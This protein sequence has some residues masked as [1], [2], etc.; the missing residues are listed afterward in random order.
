MT[1][2]A[3]RDT[4]RI[5]QWLEEVAD[6][7]IPVLSVVDLGIVREVRW[8]GDELVVTVTPTYSGCPA[9]DAINHAIEQ[10]LRDHGVERLRL[11]TRL[12]PAWTTDWLTEKGRSRLR[13]FGITPPA[14]TAERP[15]DISALRRRREA[16]TV[17]CPR[18]GSTDTARVSQ[19]GATACKAQYRCNACLEPFDYFKPH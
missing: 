9:V 17:A 8:A 5:W 11:E 3:Q 2:A 12:A 15:I 6:P 10:A 4:A 14:G 1:A 18:C 7:E 13:E 19:F 16:A